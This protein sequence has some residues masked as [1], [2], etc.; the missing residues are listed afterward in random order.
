MNCRKCSYRNNFSN[1]VRYALMILMIGIIPVSLERIVHYFGPLKLNLVLFLFFLMCAVL[2]GYMIEK[3]VNSK[4]ILATIF[5]LAASVR[6]ACFLSVDSIPISDFNRAYQAGRRLFVE[7]NNGDFTDTAY[8]A[9]FTH[10]IGI[11]LYF[12]LMA[13]EFV[14]AL[15][16]IK[17]VN[18]AL[19][20]VTVFIIYKLLCTTVGKNTKATYVATFLAALFPPFIVYS[21]VFCSENLAMPLF[22]WSVY[23]FIRAINNEMKSWQL[24]VSGIA[25]SIGNMFRMVGVVI[26]IGYI[27]FVF[28]N[29]DVKKFIKL[30]ITAILIIA[31]L[32]PLIGTDYLV[33]ANGVTNYHLWKGAEPMWTSIL[34]GSNQEAGG[35]WNVDDASVFNNNGR[36]YDRTEIACKE[37]VKER[38]LNTPIYKSL[39]FLY[40]KFVMIWREGDFYG[41]YWSELGLKEAYNKDQ[42][43]ADMNSKGNMYVELS[44]DGMEYIQIYYTAIVLLAY[45]SLYVV[46]G[47]QI[48]DGN[49]SRDSYLF[50]YIF[51]GFGLLYL[52]TESQERYAYIACWLFII[53]AGYSLE[54]IFND[55]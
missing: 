28:I 20:M 31:F 30:K 2:V 26:L 53:M 38:Y 23:L 54:W 9:R 6:I 25:L 51:C 40:A 13:K 37:I 36:D 18:I 11:S 12:G 7:G 29:L 35:K 42:Y 5:I 52:I 45:I 8:I 55:S 46:E 10:L 14:N 27:M 50:Y 33:R 22:L 1:F 48:K 47:K 34:R 41:A 49:R 39:G 4:I 32:L 21:N 19:S 15:I 44:K 17:V 24:L 16:W 3:K 43:L